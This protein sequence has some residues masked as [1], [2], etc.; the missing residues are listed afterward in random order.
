MARTLSRPS[1][2]YQPGVYGPYGIDRITNANTGALEWSATVEGDWPMDSTVQVM[3]VTLMWDTG[4]GARWTYNGGLLNRDGTPRTL[5][6][7]RVYVPRE[8]DGAGGIR[9]GQVSGA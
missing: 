3:R 2:L 9:R 8:A 1:Q 6:T 4:A 7:E 5:I